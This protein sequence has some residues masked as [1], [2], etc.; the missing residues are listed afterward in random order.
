MRTIGRIGFLVIAILSAG[1][2]AAGDAFDGSRACSGREGV[3]VPRP[4]QSF[5][6]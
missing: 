1:S 5:R 4:R 3:T 2:I 6:D